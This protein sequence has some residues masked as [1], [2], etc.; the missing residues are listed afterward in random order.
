ML[1]VF[2][3]TLEITMSNIEQPTESSG[4]PQRKPHLDMTAHITSMPASHARNNDENAP[5]IAVTLVGRPW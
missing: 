1:A 2:I 4:A 3:S 5:V